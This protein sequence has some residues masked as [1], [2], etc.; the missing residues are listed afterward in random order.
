MIAVLLVVVAVP[1]GVAVV[2]QRSGRRP[3]TA[4]HT[5]RL[6]FPRDLTSDAVEALFAGIAALAPPLQFP[7]G[8]TP[9]LVPRS[10]RRGGLDRAP[11]DRAR[12]FARGR[13]EHAAGCLA[14]CPNR[15]DRATRHVLRPSPSSPVRD[16]AGTKQRATRVADRRG[17]SRLCRH[18]GCPTAPSLRRDHRHPVDPLRHANTA[19]HQTD[20]CAPTRLPRPSPSSP[21]TR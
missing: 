4:T 6:I 17:T 12:L 3:D 19:A 11:T 18:V 14:W 21:P 7:W 9:R 16:R 5:L 8:S 2:V 20:R 13:S 1:L 10:G 15:G